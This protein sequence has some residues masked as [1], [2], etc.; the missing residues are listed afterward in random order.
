MGNINVKII[1]I[2]SRKKSKERNKENLKR[3][4]DEIK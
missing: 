3:R 2:T 1:L 4:K